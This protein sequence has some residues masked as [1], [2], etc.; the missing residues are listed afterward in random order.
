MLHFPV[1]LEESVD[2][3]ISNVDGKYIDAT[4]GR[5]GHSK[6]ILS[7]LSS[8]GHLSAFDKD[9][10]AIKFSKNFNESNFNSFHDS[11][12]NLTKY[13]DNKSIDGVIYDLGTCS[14]HFDDPIRGFSFNKDGP[15]DMRFDNT[16][17]T[18]LAE[19]LNDALEE[20]IIEILYLSLIHISEPTRR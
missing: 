4:F 2:F 19:W 10:D 18:S 17:G 16:K 14:T 12:K 20:E 1:L 3:L 5:G 6:L 11:F 7:K 15:L 8:K 9:P 13:F